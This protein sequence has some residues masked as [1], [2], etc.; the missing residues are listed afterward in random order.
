MVITFSSVMTKLKAAND[1]P[2][3]PNFIRHVNGN[4][5]DNRA[6]NLAV[7]TLREAFNNIATWR[8]DW[9]CYVTEEEVEFV[10]NLLIARS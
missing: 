5:Q 10:K 4:T 2:G 1:Y 3:Y 7:V 9:V 6:S 8:V